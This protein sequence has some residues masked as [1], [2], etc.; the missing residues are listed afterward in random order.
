MPA[1]IKA[2]EAI[3]KAGFARNQSEALRFA[4]QRAVRWI[5]EKAA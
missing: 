3:K 4:L 2:I 5:A 1:D